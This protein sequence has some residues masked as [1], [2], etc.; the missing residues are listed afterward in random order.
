MK[1]RLRLALLA[2]ALLA[3]GCSSVGG[4]TG[5]VAGVA[6][7]SATANPAVAVAV[8]IGVKAGVDETINYALRY[9]AAE[10]QAQIATAVGGMSVGE[11]KAWS[12]KH[13]LPYDNKQGSVTVVRVFTTPLATCKEAV[14][15]VDGA[16]SANAKPERFVTTACRDAAGWRWA[17]A[18]PAVSRWGALQ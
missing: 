6:S 4:V 11:K 3:Q 16:A 2:G 13:K 18:E 17:V 12:V 5:A 7:G 8:G 9:W 1:P 15:W 10:E 14:F